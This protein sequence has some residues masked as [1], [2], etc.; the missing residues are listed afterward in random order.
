VWIRGPHVAA[1]DCQHRIRAS[2][3]CCKRKLDQNPHPPAARAVAAPSGRRPT[4]PDLIGL[5][6]SLIHRPEGAVVHALRRSNSGRLARIGQR[7]ARRGTVDRQM[8]Q[9]ELRGPLPEVGRESRRASSAFRSRRFSSSTLLAVRVCASCA[10]SSRPK[11]CACMATPQPPQTWTSDRAAS[12]PPPDSSPPH[13]SSSASAR[14][15]RSDGRVPARRS[16][17]TR[18]P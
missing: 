16:L 4:D 13:R 5:C 12:A 14:S 10:M 11:S 6:E 3:F 8:R 7:L 17:P 15:P 9:D 1:E 2:R 18:C